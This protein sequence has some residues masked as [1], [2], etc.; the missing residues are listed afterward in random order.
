MWNEWVAQ[1]GIMRKKGRRRRGGAAIQEKVV[2]DRGGRD[3][4]GTGILLRAPLGLEGPRGKVQSKSGQWYNV[5]A[6][7]FG[8]DNTPEGAGRGVECWRCTKEAGAGTV[9]G[10]END[11]MGVSDRDHAHYGRQGTVVGARTAAA[12]GG[13]GG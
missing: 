3:K 2:L 9:A 8:R 13:A 1:W 12:Q 10:A 4:A 5:H 7:M 6:D 11:G